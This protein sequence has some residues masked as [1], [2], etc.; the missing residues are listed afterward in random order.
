MQYT[1][2]VHKK[3][4]KNTKYNHNRGCNETW[5]KMTEPRLKQLW[6]NFTFW[7]LENCGG[8][9]LRMISDSKLIS[10]CFHKRSNIYLNNQ[11]SQVS[12]KLHLNFQYCWLLLQHLWNWA[13]SHVWQGYNVKTLLFLVA[14]AR[15]KLFVG[16]GMFQK[17]FVKPV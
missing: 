12:I 9:Y 14:I 5:Y 6:Y 15:T 2:D 7:R 11:I 4:E 1:K 10:P 8:T 13:Q 17:I 16:F 3:I